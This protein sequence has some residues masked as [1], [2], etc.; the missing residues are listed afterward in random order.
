M[1][2]ARRWR[3][4]HHRG[5]SSRDKHRNSKQIGAPIPQT[6]DQLTV[7]PIVKRKAF[8]LNAGMYPPKV[9]DSQIRALIRELSGAGARLTGAALRAALGE[10]YGS[11]GGVS[12]IYRL[13]GD[14]TRTLPATPA[15]STAVPISESTQVEAL[16]AELA[17]A[18]AREESHQT[19]WALE[20]D[21]L[22]QTLA[23]VEPLALEARQ[24]RL[25]GDLLRH[26]LQAAERRISELEEQIIAMQAMPTGR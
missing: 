23:A 10:R 16:R 24:L 5:T 4:E 8:R 1:N 11:R 22:R 12:R 9:S 21:R 2:E 14:A 26:Q 17:L 25:S 18:V 15:T 7:R 20:I 3:V 19:R 6:D 13:L